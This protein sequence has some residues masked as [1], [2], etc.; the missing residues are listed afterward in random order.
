MK[1]DKNVPVPLYRQVQEVLEEK[2]TSKQWE[3]GYQLPTEQELAEHF[4][5]STI[6]V[7]RAVLELVSK[8][9]LYRQSGKGTF[10][11]GTTN[12]L[13]INKLLVTTSV[14]D[15]ESPHELLSFSMELMGDEVAGKF[16]LQ[17]GAKVF[18]IKRLKIENGLPT[19]LEYSY[20]PFDKCPTLTPNDI[21][22][23]FIYNILKKKFKISLGRA[24]MFVKPFIAD[25]EMAERLEIE[26]G[27]PIFEWEKFTYTK[28][29][30]VI[31]YSKFY[32]RPDKVTYYTE[33]NFS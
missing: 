33:I 14:E 21:N 5:V 7:K 12:E 29:G 15:V 6:T 26:A 9:Y 20:L 31:E 18:K 25:S 1:I 19:H 32:V 28:Q 24:R 11:A 4:D 13:D 10:V 3:I 27:T 22:N 30:E 17:S 23:E 8:G 2:I 16:G